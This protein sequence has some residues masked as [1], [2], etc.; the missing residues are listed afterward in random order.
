L[1][2]HIVFT[3]KALLS[4]VVSNRS[5]RHLGSDNQL[6]GFSKDGGPL[7]ASLRWGHQRLRAQAVQHLLG[8]VLMEAARS[9]ELCA[10]AAAPVHSRAQPT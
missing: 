6:G 4:A 9:S 2:A 10:L 5:R 3:R 8:D 1:A 7:W